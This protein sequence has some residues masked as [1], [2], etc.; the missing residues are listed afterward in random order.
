MDEETARE[1]RGNVLSCSRVVSVGN[2]KSGGRIIPEGMH[3]TIIRQDVKHGF[4]VEAQV[5]FD[6]FP[7]TVTTKIK[8]LRCEE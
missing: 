5:I 8:H 7:K 6:G 1:I 3:G 2:I 4:Q